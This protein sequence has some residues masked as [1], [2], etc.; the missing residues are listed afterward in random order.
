MI[1]PSDLKAEC[2]VY[3][4]TGGVMA[5]PNPFNFTTEEARLVLTLEPHLLRPFKPT[6]NLP[7]N[8]PP[9]GIRSVNGQ[10]LDQDEIHSHVHSIRAWH[11]MA[12]SRR[13]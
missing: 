8:I 7:G 11:P 2:P 13:L 1:A 5:W 10:T 9:L 12:R 4:C 3:I 6:I